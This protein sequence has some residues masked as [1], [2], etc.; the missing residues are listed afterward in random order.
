[1][2][3]YE[4]GSKLDHYLIEKVVAKSGMATL[5]RAV[6]ERD[7]RV[8]AL[9]VPHAEMQSDPILCE[10]FERE[11]EIGQTMDHPGVVK[12]FQNPGR[13]G[14]YMVMEWA[15]GRLLRYLMHEEKKMPPERAIAI[16][17]RI[18]DALDYLHKH[19]IVHRD[20]KP[21]NIIIDDKDNIKLIDFG[22]AAKADTGRITFTSIS[23]ILGTPDYIS[24]EQVKGKR[25]DPRSDIYALGVMLYEMLTGEIPFHGPNSLAV[26]ND[27]VVNNP[28]P[29]RKVAPEQSPQLQEILFRALERE[30]RHRY[31]TA[32]EF[33]WDLT[34]PEL[35][36]AEDRTEQTPGKK[37]KTPPLK[38][39]L[40]YSLLGLIPLALFVL[41]LMLA[42]HK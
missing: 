42:K 21:E 7:Q 26:M 41:M 14:L 9:K 35:V 29:L 12:V 38:A 1:M 28:T 23:E 33:S 6:D 40:N 5:Y 30:P 32:L 8:V 25:G 17:L 4:P 36:G 19:G 11:E 39:I 13:S 37:R 18:C 27:R 3:S 2:T 16:T 31:G 34:H 20:L 24:P 15:E 22:I 10:R